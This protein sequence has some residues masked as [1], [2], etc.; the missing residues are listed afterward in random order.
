[1]FF[2]LTQ[3]VWGNMNAVT[4]FIEERRIFRHERANGYYSVA[5]YFFPKV[6]SVIC[7]L[8]E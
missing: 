4:V 1:M 8:T 5:A 2:M 6:T 7:H 3:M